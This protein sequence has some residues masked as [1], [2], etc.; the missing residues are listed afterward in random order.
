MISVQC[1]PNQAASKAIDGIYIPSHYGLSEISNVA[2]T[3]IEQS[4][5]IQID[6]GINHFVEGVKIWNR[7]EFSLPGKQTK[8]IFKVL[9]YYIIIILFYMCF[10]SLLKKINSL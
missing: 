8:L 7:S 1:T 5:W 6:L 2:H 10:M 4:P 3:K 9:A